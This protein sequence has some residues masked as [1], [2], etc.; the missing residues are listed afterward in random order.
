VEN[1]ERDPPRLER[2]GSEVQQDGRILAP[3]EEQDRALRLSGHLTNDEDGQGFQK[4]EVPQGVL[5][6]PD[7]GRHRPTRPDRDGSR[8]GVVL[9]GAEGSG[10]VHG[11]SQIMTI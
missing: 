4:V 1:G 10:G 8:D 5:D 7:Q 6:G 11:A 2:L 9:W 3:A